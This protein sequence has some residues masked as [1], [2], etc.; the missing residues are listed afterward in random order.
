MLC[1]HSRRKIMQKPVWIQLKIRISIVV[2]LTFVLEFCFSFPLFS[3]LMFICSVSPQ[4][5]EERFRISRKELI[6]FEFTILV[7][8]EMALYLPESH[9]MPHYRRLLQQQQ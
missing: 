6:F 7:A 8:L 5:L 1:L 4:K 2:H 9:V 3:A